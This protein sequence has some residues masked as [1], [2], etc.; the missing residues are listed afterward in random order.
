MFCI[1]EIFSAK[2]T[3]KENSFSIHHTT[4][5]PDP[6]EQSCMTLASWSRIRIKF[7]RHYLKN[8]IKLVITPPPTHDHPSLSAK[9]P[10]E[11]QNATQVQIFKCH[12]LSFLIPY[13]NL[14]QLL[15][16]RILMTRLTVVE[17]AM[18]C[19]PPDTHNGHRF[20]QGRPLNAPQNDDSSN[21]FLLSSACFGIDT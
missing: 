3:N 18:E 5:S 20:I 12:P 1:T 16:Y 9:T 19:H 8:C 6:T 14:Q 15:K 10:V 4:T 21:V 11:T 17:S 13:Q 2:E 7:S